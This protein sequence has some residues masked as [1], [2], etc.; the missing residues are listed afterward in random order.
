MARL[1]RYLLYEDHGVLYSV[2]VRACCDAVY[3]AGEDS[4]GGGVDEWEEVEV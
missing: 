4:G 2:L 1:V 3:S